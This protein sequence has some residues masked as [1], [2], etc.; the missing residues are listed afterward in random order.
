MV[1]SIEE[2]TAEISRGY[3]NSR[4]ALQN[5]INAI[6]ENLEQTRKKIDADYGLRQRELNNQSNR[7]A[8]S[9]SLQ[10]AANGTGFGGAAQIANQKY[11]E[12]AFVPAQAQLHNDWSNSRDNAETQANSNRLSLESQL[13]SMN[14]EISRLGVQR[15][16]DEMEREREEA[17]RQQ[18][19]AL[20]RQ[21][22][23]AQNAWQQY[24]NSAS[25]G[26]KYI[27]AGSDSDYQFRDANTGEAVKMSTFISQYG[28]DFNQRARDYLQ[29]MANNGAAD[30]RYVLNLLN[31]NPNKRLAAGTSYY[32]PSIR[33]NSN[34]DNTA[35]NILGLR[36]V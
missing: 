3:D 12:Q 21:Q 22:I 2:Y 36:L 8:Q 14:D 32:D 35:L 18:Q 26:D 10:S 17:Y 33:Y 19:L 20:Q 15:Y 5:Q 34:R 13:A 25:Q 4:N 16:Y 31:S 24:M 29:Q 11:Y 7:A 23:A 1:K 28:G 9:A 30:A 27:N 6:G